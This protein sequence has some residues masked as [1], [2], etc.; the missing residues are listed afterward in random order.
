MNYNYLTVGDKIDI[1]IFTDFE[2]EK[3]SNYIQSLRA[4]I[5]DKNITTPSPKELEK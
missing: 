3:M 1:K 4:I 5:Q 2:K